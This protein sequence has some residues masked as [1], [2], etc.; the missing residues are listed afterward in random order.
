VTGLAYETITANGTLPLLRPMSEV[1]GRMS[2][3]VG[4]ALLLKPEG[5]RGILL[6]GVPGVPPGHV[7]I[8]GGGVVGLN[9]AKIAVGLGARVTV[10]ETSAERMTRLDDL[11]GGRVVTLASNAY[12]LASAVE[13][14]DLLVGAVLI[15]GAATPRVVTRQMIHSMRKG[16][17]AVDV[18]V[19]QGGC[20]ET[21]R[22]TTHADPVYD[23]EGITH[24]CVDNMA[25]VVPRT[26]TLALTNAT[27]P[28][29]VRLA[30]YGLAEALRRDA[31]LRHGVNTYDGAVTCEPVARAQGKPFRAL[32]ELLR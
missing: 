27:L 32:E 15:P 4:A 10:L 20:F 28:Y 1:A 25:G 5:G 3:Q 18:S 8:V 7:V 17:V 22:A 13:A 26:S 12:T 2:V 11:F 9:A 19:D 6:G 24:Y 23:A 30:R 31:G 29:A 21:S 16:S 14:A